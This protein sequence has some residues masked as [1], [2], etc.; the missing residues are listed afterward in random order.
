MMTKSPTS[1]PPEPPKQP[2]VIDSMAQDW[3][4]LMTS[5][6]PSDHDRADFRCWLSENPQHR[7]AYNELSDLWADI[8][9]LQDAF[10]P[11][12]ETSKDNSRSITVNKVDNLTTSAETHYP[13]PAWDAKQRPARK[14]MVRNT[15][16]GGAIAACL[17]LLL[18]NAP[19]ISTHWLSDHRTAAGEQA[20]IELPDG[21][22]A[23]LN[24]DTAIDVRYNDGRREVA[25]LRGEAQFDVQK[26]P[27]RPFVVSANKGQSTALGTLYTVRKQDDAV[28]V[29]VSEGSVEVVSPL[30]K[31]E[32]SIS[33]SAAHGRVVLKHGEQA[34]YNTG[35]PPGTA[36]QAQTAVDLAWR[37]G[38]IA[39]RNLP[40]A[41]ALTEIGRYHPGR[42][43]LLADADKL[44]PVTARLAI[45]SLD[46][47]LDALA[48]TQGLKV[49]RLTD[50]LVLVR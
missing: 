48:A 10:A 44:Q 35:E 31:A 34:R 5:G 23:W 40:L 19:T 25:L 39:I 21:S 27:S 13:S 29:I 11:S 50:Y 41:D 18:V 4:L 16:W 12:T 42:I 28:L 32:G 3:F 15:F 26:N 2:A 17:A 30:A 36:E 45:N 8:D 43:V 20:R 24:T 6:Q 46:N 37:K 33:D 9:N 47:G 14:S 49:T 38:F 7:Q 22:I 1:Q